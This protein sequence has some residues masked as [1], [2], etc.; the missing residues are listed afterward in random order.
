MDPDAAALG[1]PAQGG[2]AAEGPQ[3]AA[4]GSIARNLIESLGGAIA[5]LSKQPKVSMLFVFLPGRIDD[6][7]LRLFP[8]FV[9]ALE[10]HGGLTSLHVSNGPFDGD[11]E[12]S[13][14]WHDLE[15][16][17]GTVLPN[18]PRLKNISFKS[19]TVSPSCA[20]SF[21]SALLPANRRLRLH[22]RFEDTHLAPES[23]RALAGAVRGGAVVDLVLHNARLDSSSAG[24]LFQSAGHSK[25][26]RSIEL[27]GGPRLIENWTLTEDA[28]ADGAMS[29][30]TRLRTLVVGANWTDGGYVELFRQLRVNVTLQRLDMYGADHG[31]IMFGLVVELLTTYNFTIAM[32]REGDFDR[33]NDRWRQKVDELLRRNERVRRVNDQLQKHAYHLADPKLWPRVIRDVGPFPTLVYRFL[34]K[35][36]TE[37]L[38][39][40][41][42]S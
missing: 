39:D 31:L 25:R 2:H 33:P 11:A 8:Q 1:G 23:C 24:V 20:S 29:G 15:R 14:R 36:N 6:E 16:L 28:W 32:F 42:R 19:C 17:F 9:N 12:G 38:S 22:M 37:A 7:D 3:Q 13:P 26:L 10:S 4:F 35:G 40:Q 5:E 34:R 18:L 21:F 41:L 30:A 27:T